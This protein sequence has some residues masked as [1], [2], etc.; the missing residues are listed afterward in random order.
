MLERLSN[1]SNI[2]WLCLI[3]HW[4]ADFH[5][6]G[7]LADL[8]QKRWWSDKIKSEFYHDTLEAQHKAFKLYTH[9]YLAGLYVHAL[10]WS[11]ITFL[12]LMFIMHPMLYAGVVGVNAVAH[13]I[14][15]HMKAN[16]HCINLCE[17]QILHLLQVTTS[18]S[19]AFFINQYV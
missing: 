8:K 5:L 18:T 14:I 11:A 4:F 1:P 10:E 6:Q 2:M 7:I 9:D 15:D 17:D 12:P 19:F 16:M 3:L 13:M